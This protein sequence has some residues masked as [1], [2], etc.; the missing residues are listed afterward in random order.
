MKTSTGQ[1]GSM[2]KSQEKVLMYIGCARNVD[3]Q[4]DIGSTKKQQK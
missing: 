3:G 4:K 1:Q 2:E